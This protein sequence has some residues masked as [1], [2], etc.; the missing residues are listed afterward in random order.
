MMGK[1]CTYMYINIY[2]YIYLHAIHRSYFGSNLH[3]SPYRHSIQGTM[4]EDCG[5][6]NKKGRSDEPDLPLSKKSK[7]DHYV[8]P[9]NTLTRK[10]LDPYGQNELDRITLANLWIKASKGDE[11]APRYTEYAVPDD[12]NYPGLA[13]SKSMKNLASAIKHL[14]DKDEAGQI[15]DAKIYTVLEAE[16]ALLEPHVTLLSGGQMQREGGG[17]LNAYKVAPVDPIS[18]TLSAKHVYGWLHGDSKLRSMLRF[19]AKGGLF[20]TAF[21]N[22]KLTRAYLVGNK[23]SEEAFVKLCVHRL[24]N[25]E[26]PDAA[27]SADRII[28]WSAVKSQGS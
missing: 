20:Y 22:E 6:F 11:H 7:N 27:S 25:S 4:A 21:C 15:I 2:I 18:A 16:C 3:V 23:L 13:L 19:L 17:K 9:G 12:L 8:S 24:S 28:D 26:A 5:L 1:L 10:M 14:M